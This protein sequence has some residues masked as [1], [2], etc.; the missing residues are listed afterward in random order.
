MIL[1]IGCKLAKSKKQIQV[2]FGFEPAD[3]ADGTNERLS[4][5]QMVHAWVDLG[6]QGLVQTMLK[7]MMLG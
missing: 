5:Q 3:A 2:L 7:M 4:S 6:G 1:H